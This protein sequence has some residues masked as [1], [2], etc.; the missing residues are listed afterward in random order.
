MR[1]IVYMSELG[2]AICTPANRD[3]IEAVLKKDCPPESLIVDVADLPAETDFVDAWR[4]SAENKVYTDMT[5]AK[6]KTLEQFNT[7]IKTVSR[8]AFI[9]DNSDMDIDVTDSEWNRILAK[10]RQRII[11]AQTYDELREIKSRCV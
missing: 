10:Y 9:G 4:I 2:I 5:I 7:Y 1:V 11:N 8:R 3:E 6:R